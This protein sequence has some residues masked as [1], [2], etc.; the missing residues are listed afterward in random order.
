MPVPPSP[1]ILYVAL[2]SAMGGVARFLIGG[3]LQRADSTFPSGTLTV[4]IAGSF[5]LGA[6]ARYAAMSPT[7]SP[8]LRLLIGAGFCGGLTTFSTFSVEAIELMQGGALARAGLYV[9]V[10][11]LTGLGAALVGMA[12]VRTILE[13]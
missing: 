13:R 1:L 12:V 2:G 9:A 7:F 5:I 10:S 6:V 11:V 8:E 4:N 3:A